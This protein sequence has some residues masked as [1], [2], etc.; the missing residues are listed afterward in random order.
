MGKVARRIVMAVA[1]LAVVFFVASFV[2]DKYSLDNSF[3]RVDPDY[4]R[5]MPT[6]EFAAAYDSRPVEFQF[7]GAT[8]R[9]YVYE[10][11]KPKGFIVFRHGITSEHAD[12]LALICAM[13]D[14]GWTVFA[15]DAIGCGISDGEHVKGMAQSPLDVAAAVEFARESGMVGDLPLVLWGHSWGGYG[16]AAALDIV[17]DVDACVTMSGYNSPVGVL[18]EF[19]G[20]MMG[21]AAVTQYP[22]M[23]LNNKLSFGD[24]ADRTAL[25]G[26]DKADVPVLVIHGTGDKV[27]EYDGSSIIAQRDRITNENVEYLVMDE[28]GRDGHNSY[29]YAAAANEYLDEKAA[30]IEE[31]EERYPDGVPKDVVEGFM[32]DYDAKRANEADPDLMN[33][34]DAF[35]TKAIGGDVKATSAG[36]YGV[37]KSAR[38]TN[39]GNSL[40]NRYELEAMPADDGSLIVCEREAK[41]HSMPTT[42]REYRADADLLDRISDVADKAGMKEWGELPLSELIAYDAPTPALTLTYDNADPAERWPVWLSVSSTCEMPDNGDAMYAIRDLMAAYAADANLIREYEEPLR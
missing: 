12:Y 35:L 25:D 17:S 39:S 9:G 29:F 27:V 23:W 18:M 33:A 34:I 21:P 15:Y 14:R 11:S 5:F 4:P 37:L 19:A 22:T 6:E 3:K 24:D 31:L 10:A 2:I 30:E 32:A 38:Y 42:V 16:V 13:V 8:L 7:Q 28:A 36:Q 20:R 1:V 40:G 41:M 26:I